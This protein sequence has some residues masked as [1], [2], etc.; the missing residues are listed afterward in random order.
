MGMPDRSDGF[1]PSLYWRGLTYD[2]SVQQ[3]QGELTMS[4]HD[5]PSLS[6][7]TLHFLHIVWLL[8]ISFLPTIGV[9][10]MKSPSFKAELQSKL[11]RFVWSEKESESLHLDRHV[12]IVKVTP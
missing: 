3:C 9:T 4:G 1:T 12:L 10:N 11:F 8:Q 7:D 5:K 2:V 6:M